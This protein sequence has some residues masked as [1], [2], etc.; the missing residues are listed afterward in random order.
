ML[1][2]RLCKPSQTLWYVDGHH[3]VLKSRA[4]EIPTIFNGF[5][6]YN[7]PEMSKHRKRQVGNMSGEV[8]Q[9]HASSFSC[10]CKVYI[11]RDPFGSL[12]VMR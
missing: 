3:E 1:E 5:V 4:C 9:Q 10:A 12:F 11:G 7:I 2:N 8:L 6:G